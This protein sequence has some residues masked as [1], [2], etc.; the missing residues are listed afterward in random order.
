MPELKRVWYTPFHW[1]G[2]SGL[3]FR[4]DVKYVDWSRVECGRPHSLSVTFV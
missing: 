1:I 3:E 2:E 4:Y